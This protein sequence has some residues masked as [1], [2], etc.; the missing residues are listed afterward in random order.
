MRQG[1]RNDGDLA[2]TGITIAVGE[3]NHQDGW[4]S[5]LSA[6]PWLFLCIFI[7]IAS[8][9]QVE[10]DP[11]QRHTAELPLVCG[12]KDVFMWLQPQNEGLD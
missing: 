2:G 7:L 8:F 11:I 12:H 6:C 5:Q 3:N 10:R 1:G 4:A 9:L